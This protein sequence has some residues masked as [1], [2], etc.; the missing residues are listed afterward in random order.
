MHLDKIGQLRHPHLDR[1]LVTRQPAGS[2]VTVEPLEGRGQ[3]LLDAP[4]QPDLGGEQGRRRAVRM[5][6]RSHLPTRVAQQLGDQLDALRQGAPC[7]MFP[8]RNRM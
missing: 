5:D 2:T 4:G 1:Q 6:Q 7:A 8:M 3:H